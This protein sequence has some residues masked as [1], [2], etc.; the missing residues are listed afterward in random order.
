MHLHTQTVKIKNTQRSVP[1]VLFNI[2]DDAELLKTLVKK[3]REIQNIILTN[4]TLEQQKYTTYT[5]FAN[6]LSKTAW[7]AFFK[8]KTGEDS[9]DV[10][11]E[12]TSNFLLDTTAFKTHASHVRNGIAFAFNEKYGFDVLGPS[13]EELELG[14]TKDIYLQSIIEGDLTEWGDSVKSASRQNPLRV[15]LAGAS[16]IEELLA[17]NISFKRLQDLTSGTSK[18]YKT[19]PL[20]KSVSPDTLINIL[21]PTINNTMSPT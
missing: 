10:F 2:Q 6:L 7:S 11:E 3:A 16:S 20:H 12:H 18:E 14:E 13:K 15:Y 9:C 21:Y 5:V 1:V 4:P 8:Q 19:I 17:S